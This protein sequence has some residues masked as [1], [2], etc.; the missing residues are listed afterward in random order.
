MTLKGTCY[1]YDMNV[2]L[3]NDTQNTRS[4]DSSVGI[5]TGYGLEDQGER[6]FESR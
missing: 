4:R 2:Y 1:T 5:V 3:G 6:E